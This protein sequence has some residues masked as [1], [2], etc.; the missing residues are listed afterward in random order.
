M[1]KF[2]LVRSDLESRLDSQVLDT[3]ARTAFNDLKI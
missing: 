1:T 3:V 2:L